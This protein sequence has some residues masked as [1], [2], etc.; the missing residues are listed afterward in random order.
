LINNIDLDIPLEI[1]PDRKA[2][3]KSTGKATGK[4]ATVPM[5]KMRTNTH[6]VPNSRG[7]QPP[8]P[9]PQLPPSYIIP[10][11]DPN[12]T[13]W[14]DSAPVTTDLG[15]SL[16]DFPSSTGE[17]EGVTLS[18]RVPAHW[19]T[20]IDTIRQKPGTNMP[21]VW[22]RRSNF[23]RWC[24]HVGMREL[25]RISQ[26]LDR[27]GRLLEPMDPS[28]RA[29]IFL[30]Q[31][32][33]AVTARADT[34]NEARINIQRIAEAVNELVAYNELAEAAD[35]I[36]TWME[37]A[38]SQASPFWQMFFTKVIV[39]EPTLKTPLA[40]LINDGHIVNDYLVETA[41]RYKIID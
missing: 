9:Q 37:G 19:V 16:V 24:I 11:V 26:E 17:T 7:S 31:Q 41:R 34:Q 8:Q 29:R 21:N 3:G 18:T 4:H 25:Y 28:L 23:V 6:S 13:S 40:M 20:A 33:G 38:T 39:E 2:T 27:E 12:D 15:Q 1:A 35:M 22:P 32:A 5:P 10:P 30:E 36:N 14:L